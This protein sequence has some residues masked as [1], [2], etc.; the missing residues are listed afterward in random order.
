MAAAATT[1][2]T[3][4]G[5]A[6]TA[7][8]AEID[9]RTLDVGSYATVR[10]TY[11]QPADDNGALV[12]GMRMSRAVMPAMTID[13][14]LSVGE[15]G[16]VVVDD[17]EATTRLL[18]E[19][20][21]PVLDQEDMITGYTVTGADRADLPGTD[22]PSPDATSVT[23]FVMRFPDDDSATRAARELEDV[24]FAVDPTEDVK[25]ALEKYPTAFIHWRPGVP[26]IGTF[27]AHRQFVISL[28]IERPQPNSQD[29]LDWVRKTLDAQVPALDSFQATQTGKL[30]GLPIDP[31][32]L[33]ARAVVRVGAP[34]TPDRDVFAAYGPTDFIENA[35]DAT[36][37]QRLVDETGLD[38]IA[39]ADSSTVLRVRDAVAG[40]R[41]ITGLIAGSSDTYDPTSA[42]AQVPGARCLQLDSKG[43]AIRQSRFRC[44]VTHGRY[45]EVVVGDDRSDVNRRAAAAYALLANSM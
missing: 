1:L 13:P 10:H 36:G 5:V 16:R 45:V 7:I 41:L 40:A 31:D 8:P 19:V 20:S 22:I 11:S 44:F 34:T 42:P 28:F 39:V 30:A 2:L 18:A 21:K 15:G 6:G 29:L 25:L 26:T 32:G 12:E 35:E 24:D 33:L 9:V 43:D 38:S 27:L 17:T 37:R 3:A 4:C 14:S 23:D